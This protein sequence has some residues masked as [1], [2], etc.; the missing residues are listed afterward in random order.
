VNPLK[1]QDSKGS[2]EMAFFDDWREITI[3]HREKNHDDNQG[4]EPDDAFE[5]DVDDLK[6][7][8]MVKLRGEVVG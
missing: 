3:N 1:P 6:K 5:D 7:K 2:S 8:M 4:E